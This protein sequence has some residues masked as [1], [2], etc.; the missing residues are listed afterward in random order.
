MSIRVIASQD[1]VPH[2]NLWV[3]LLF[4]GCI[5]ALIIFHFGAQARAPDA[6]RT[7]IPVAAIAA[8]LVLIY[9]RPL[10]FA[11]A[12]LRMIG[13]GGRQMMLVRPKKGDGPDENLCL[14]FDSGKTAYFKDIPPDRCNLR[15]PTLVVGPTTESFHWFPRSEDEYSLLA[16]EA[17]RDTATGIQQP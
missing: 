3:I 1:D 11:Q 5:L 15:P 9:P 10:Y 2:N 8:A 16:V 6:K 4:G 14:I 17:P 13:H 7:L 12:G